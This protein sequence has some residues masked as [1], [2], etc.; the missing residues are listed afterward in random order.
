MMGWLR[1][2]EVVRATPSP[3]RRPRFPPEIIGHAVYLY[4]R[5]A[6]SCREGE[7]QL[8]AQGIGISYETA[9][10]WCLKFGPYGA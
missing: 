3:Y 8:A 2:D 6:L 7:E 1:Q 5:F 4:F 10:R 9:R